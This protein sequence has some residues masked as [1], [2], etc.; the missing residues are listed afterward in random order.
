LAALAVTETVLLFDPEVLDK[1]IQLGIPVI[2]QLMSEVIKKLAEL[3]LVEAKLKDAGVTMIVPDGL[4][5]TTVNVSLRLFNT[6]S[7]NNCAVLSVP[8]VLT[9]CVVAKM[10]S[11]P[12]PF[13]LLKVSQ[14]LCE[15][16]VQLPVANNPKAATSPA[17]ML[18]V[19]TF[20]DPF[21]KGGSPFC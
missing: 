17:D 16:N 3:P 1:L 15:F 7:K 4:L 5:C 19:T 14:L 2:D 12:V 21:K 11:F 10:E 6:S 18:T 9:L 20:G 13:T 8:E